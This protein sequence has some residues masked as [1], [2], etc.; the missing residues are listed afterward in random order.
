MLSISCETSLLPIFQQAGKKSLS[1]TLGWMDEYLKDSIDKVTPWE[2]GPSCIH[3]PN[4]LGTIVAPLI[5]C[6]K[7]IINWSFC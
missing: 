6:N 3:I 2:H 7:G 5:K 4:A 1:R